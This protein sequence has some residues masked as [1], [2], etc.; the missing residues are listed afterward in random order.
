MQDAERRKVRKRRII[1]KT[2]I[3]GLIIFIS[4][5]FLQRLVMPKYATEIVEGGMIAEYYQ[6]EK[7]HDVIFIGDCE[8]YE[9][10]SPQVLWDDFGINSYIRGSAQQ[11]IWQSY[12][13]LEDTLRYEVPEVVVF[14][15]QSMQ[16]DRPDKEAY[17]RMTIDGLEWSMA[18]IGIIKASMTE[19]ENYLDYIFPLLRYHS[20]WNDIGQED[21]EYLFD[22]P[23]VT[24]NGYYMRVDTKAAE[25]VPTGKPLANY[26]FG[27]VDYEYLDKLT[28]LCK[29]NNIKLVLIK[30][31]SLYPYWYD[32]WEKQVE[33]YAETN[34]IL[35]INFL[36]LAEEIGLDFSQDTYDGGLHMNLSGAE[37]ITKYLGEILMEETELQDRRGEEILTARWEE[38]RKRYIAD[39]EEQYEGSED[40]ENKKQRERI[41]IVKIPDDEKTTVEAAQNNEDIEEKN[42]DNGYAFIYKNVVIGINAEAD[43][44][45]EKLGEANSYFEAASCAFNGLD[46]MYTYSSFE[47]DTYPIEGKDYI[48][49]LLFKDDTIATAEGVSIGDPAEKITEIYGDDSVKENGM[50]VYKKD[51]MKL[52]FL[53]DNESISSIEYQTTVLDE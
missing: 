50:I 51:D 52:C 6:E 35:Y 23:R 19:E 40:D 14:N 44:I 20:R 42:C 41:D 31:P 46:K 37:K 9:N 38:K 13:V 34:G 36:E 16:F 11:L 5:Y 25:N 15:V 53:I 18:K 2:F 29:L 4:L 10:F 33:E 22:T 8:V 1:C 7:D 3:S 47:L 26:R 27:E 48:S 24:H 30:A 43:P 12:Y 49:M 28:R 17:N 39:R 45:L 32:Q 21:L